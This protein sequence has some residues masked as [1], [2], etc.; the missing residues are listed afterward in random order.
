MWLFKVISPTQVLFFFR[1]FIITN[2]SSDL[3]SVKFKNF[4]KTLIGIR[5]LSTKKIPL[6]RYEY[7]EL[8]EVSKFKLCHHWTNIGIII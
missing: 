4:S 8:Y 7:Y 2:I 1:D 6:W 3:S 5:K